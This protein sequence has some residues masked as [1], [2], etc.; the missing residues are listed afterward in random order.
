MILREVSKDTDPSPEF[1]DDKKFQLEF[2]RRAANF[3]EFIFLDFFY[4]GPHIFFFT[5]VFFY[6]FILLLSVLRRMTVYL[7]IS[8]WDERKKN[9]YE[10]S[11]LARL[12][13]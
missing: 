5:D 11:Q 1:G 13:R 2:L 9:Q 4:R 6:F 7:I 3:L 8:R 10:K 12:T